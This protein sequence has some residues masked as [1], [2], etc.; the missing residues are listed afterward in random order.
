MKLWRYG[1]AIERLGQRYRL[2]GILGSGGMAD[3]CLAWDEREEQE[4]AVKV[5]KPG[6]LDQKTLDRFLKEADQMAQW[7]H[8]NILRI[9]GD[10]RLELL[11]AAQG[12]IVPYIVMEHVQGGDLHHRLRPGKPYPFPDTLS[13]FDQLCQAVA[14]A[15]EH[16]VIHR[17]LKPLNILFRRLSDGT[18][19]VVL[20]DFGLAVEIDASH[21]TFAG[22]GTLPYMAPEQLNGQAQPA[23]DIFALGVILY[24]LCTGHLPFLRT[25]EALRRRGPVAP[26][27]PP[28]TLNPL[29]PA[30]LD[31]VILTALAE[32]PRDRFA[33]AGNLWER[34]YA[35]ANADTLVEPLSQLPRPIVS[36]LEDE[37]TMLRSSPPARSSAQKQRQSPRRETDSLAARIGQ[38]PTL[39]STDP[40]AH[41]LSQSPT[42]E[43]VDA[44]GFNRSIPVRG[45][46]RGT[47]E[48]RAVSQVPVRSSARASQTAHQVDEQAE[49]STTGIP[50]VR[51]SDPL[52]A[53]V[54]PQSDRRISLHTTTM[55]AWR[56]PRRKLLL[57]LGLLFLVLVVLGSTFAFARP[58][59]INH[60]GSQGAMPSITITPA[61]Q[62]L[63]NSYV[64][65]AVAGTPD[66]TL[67]QV[68]GLRI[69][70]F[71]TPMQTKTVTGHGHRQTSGVAATGTL[72]FHNEAYVSQTVKAGTVLTGKSG[73]QVIIDKDVVIPPATGGT[74]GADGSIDVPVHA[75][76]PGANGNIAAYDFADQPCCST[77]R[78]IFVRNTAAFT[79]GQGP[80][81]YTF[82]E[83]NDV[84]VVANALKGS[85]LMQGQKGIKTQL[86]AGEQL[87]DISCQDPAISADQKIGDVGANIPSTTITVT[88]TCRGIAYRPMLAQ[89]LARSLLSSDAA[90]NP[91]EGYVLVKDIVIR[92]AVRAA[93]V[94]EAALA[95]DVRGVW[96]YQF[97]SAIKHD[98]LAKLAGKSVADARAL[99][100]A[101]KGI[102]DVRIDL[103]GGETILPEDIGQ[104]AL[105]I[106]PVQGA[107]P[108][109]GG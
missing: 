86:R 25:I 54:A 11:D 14:Y 83:Q 105:Q 63:Q 46:V 100:K 36:L 6:E 53:S 2:E 69:L 26:P 101:Y 85:L 4:V 90:N 59:L 33:S 76:N 52:L 93:T 80:Q 60:P 72:T 48:R 75:V 43:A 88:Q 35:V 24:Q 30:E 87:A 57:T 12:S 65:T 18:E 104:I 81:D 94:D 41:D 84:Q 44:A 106:Q 42:H 74:S 70:S 47:Q 16:G 38:S 15:H 9:Y 108:F 79:G 89:D 5:I 98:L 78:T 55:L 82:V 49:D 10:T 39:E 28:T 56:P 71:T 37:S 91:G 21:F 13:V 3:A 31:D 34:V 103:N 92:V 99:L 95:V 27:V 58:G 68:G 107:E 97:T 32:D 102:G 40:V 66:P 45:H 73:I 77:D 50:S 20:S 22:A 62:L 7:R 8:P 1:K 109:A 23:S 19:Q 17:D 96:A 64:V 51:E 29:L 61:S 67:R